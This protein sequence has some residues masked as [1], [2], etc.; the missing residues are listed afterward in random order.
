MGDNRSVLTAI[1]IWHRIAFR[2]ALWAVLAAFVIGFVFAAMQIYLDFDSLRR[3][4]KS[5]ALQIVNTIKKPAAAAAFG[6]DDALANEVADGLFEY[7]PIVRIRLTDDMNGVLVD[8]RRDSPVGKYKW[9]TSQLFSGDMEY[10]IQLKSTSRSSQIVGELVVVVDPSTMAAAFYERALISLSVGV[11]RSIIMAFLFVILFYFMLTKPLLHLIHGMENIDPNEPGNTR[12]STPSADRNDEL[13]VLADR[14]NQLLGSIGQRM[15]E[16]RG[17]EEDLKQKNKIIEATLQNMDEGIAMYDR[18]Q[19][20]V[21]YNQRFIELGN[22]PIGQ[23][24]QGTPLIEFVRYNAE[25]GEYGPG[26]PEDLIVARM[27]L[28][29]RTTAHTRE[30]VRPNGQ[31]LEI[32]G[33]PTSDGGYVMTYTDITP[34]K[35]AELEILKAKD[36]AEIASRAKTDFL[37]NMSHELRTPLNGII[38]FSEIIGTEIYGKINNSR[39]V[40]YANDIERAGLHL[41]DVI[42]SI[43]DVAK[44]EAG[45]MELAEEIFNVTR[46]ARVCI[47]LV[48]PQAEAKNIHLVSEM[49]EDTPDLFADK[50]RIKQIMINLLSNAIKF[51]PENGDV[52]MEIGL[53]EGSEALFMEVR[54]T[55][56]GIAEEEIDKVMNPFYQVDDVFTRTHE[57]SGLGLALVNSMA[58]LHGATIK[59]DSVKDQGTTVRI[60]FPPD[61]TC[62]KPLETVVTLAT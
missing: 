45:K 47:G 15:E 28:A 2:Q 21:A 26:Q 25:N 23:F 31:V 24:P 59:V 22:Y 57:G 17:I 27:E 51:T 58:G 38:G 20:V 19:I 6:Y 48:Q 41:L 62:P 9:L 54:D 1:P 16:R 33:N 36:Q 3:A 29:R 10:K 5:E 8:R 34:R 18:N 60:I 32:R 42:N 11:V 7:R 61:R 46:V 30:R 56:I 13:Q 53:V 52:V 50:V 39:Y 43:L 14:A 35:Q 55:G 4:L 12:L 40:E 37:A 44:I 49:S